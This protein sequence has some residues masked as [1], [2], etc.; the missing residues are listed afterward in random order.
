MS[1]FSFNN[2]PVVVPVE[3]TEEPV[4]IVEIE[5]VEDYYAEVSEEDYASAYE[6]DF[7]DDV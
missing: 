7:G 5:P 4:E 6:P 3:T 1:M 2:D